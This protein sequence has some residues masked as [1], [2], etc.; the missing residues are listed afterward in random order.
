[1]ALLS[2]TQISLYAANCTNTAV[3]FIPLNDLGTGTYH[4]FQGGLYPE[5]ANTRPPAHERAGL[6]IS[7]FIQPLDLA[8]EPNQQNGV[9]VLL[10][11]GMSN[12]A[13]EFSRFISIAQQDPEKN[14]KLV[15]VNGA[16]S[17]WSADEIADPTAEFWDIV[18]ERLATAGLTPKQVQIVW[19]KEADAK[20]TLPFP[21]DAFQLARELGLIV[22]ILKARY[23][24]VKMA[25]LSS[26]IYAGYAQ[27]DLNPEPFAYQSG[28]AV[29]WLIEQQIEGNPNLN[30]NPLQGE[31]KTP[32]LSWGPYLWADGLNPRSDGL[33]WE[34]Q[35]FRDDGTHPSSE[36]GTWKVAE[37]LLD[38][39]KTDS[40]TQRWFLATPS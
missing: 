13:Q 18:D 29:K 6:V 31:V 19:L 32:W 5:G 21:E 35:D 25:Y 17:Q 11:I 27:T 23:P 15:L 36:Q 7:Q 9:I 40:T 34:C 22:Q 26:R 24:N 33:I 37:M 3:G 10:S 8:G 12:A 30:F 28:F 2:W 14:P 20:P 4:G 1:M 16:Q 38:F 39:F